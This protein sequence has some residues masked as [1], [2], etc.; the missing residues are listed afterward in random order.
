MIG[1]F[2]AKYITFGLKKYRRVIFHDTED[3]CKIWIKAD[4]CFGEWHDEFDKSSSEYL[5][6]SKLVLSWDPL[7]Q[8]RKY[9]KMYEEIM[10]YDTKE[11]WKIWREIDF[12]F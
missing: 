2:C 11:W 4:L 6:V 5:K 8:S 10:C 9:M 7:V 1:P 3:S 12:S